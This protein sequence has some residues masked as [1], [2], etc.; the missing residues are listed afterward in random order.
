MKGRAGGEEG[1][2][3]ERDVVEEGRERRGK[4]VK[5]RGG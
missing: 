3:S 1:K 5:W 4:T 2:G